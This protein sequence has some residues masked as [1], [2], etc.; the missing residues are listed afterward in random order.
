MPQNAWSTL[1]QLSY[2]L[3]ASLWLL[4]HR[5]LRD[6]DELRAIRSVQT[7]CMSIYGGRGVP[8]HSGSIQIAG[9]LSSMVESNAMHKKLAT[10]Y[11][12]Q[13]PNYTD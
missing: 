12:M 7:V 6:G 5:A 2:N 13:L 9:Q 11:G 8:K 1:P 10:V 3:T 4:L